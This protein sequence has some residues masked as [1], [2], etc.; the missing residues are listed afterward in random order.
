M[1]ISL[2]EFKEASSGQQ[3]QPTR[4]PVYNNPDQRTGLEGITSMFKE[5]EDI[6]EK[7]NNSNYTIET[8]KYLADRQK[9]LDA[10]GEQVT[11]GQLTDIQAKEEVSKYDTTQQNTYKTRLPPTYHTK[12]NELVQTETAKTGQVIDSLYKATVDS[13]FL[14]EANNTIEQ[15]KKQPKD[16]ALSR[17][18]TILVD[19]R[20]PLD[21]QTSMRNGFLKEYDTNALNGMVG[22]TENLSIMNDKGEVDLPTTLT[23]R[24]DKLRELQIQIR[25]N[26]TVTQNL[27]AEQKTAYDLKISDSIARNE[28]ELARYNASVTKQQEVTQKENEA[29]VVEYSKQVYSGVTP[30]EEL[31]AQIQ[32][33]DPNA[34]KEGMATIKIISDYKLAT[35][36]QRQITR[37]ELA[38]GI[39]AGSYKTIAERQK[40]IDLLAGLERADSEM[41]TREKEDPVGV[42]NERNPSAKLQDR[43]YQSRSLALAQEGSKIIPYTQNEIANM[44]GLWSTSNNRSAILNQFVDNTK[45]LTPDIANKALY[46]Q[47]ST[48]VSGD[49]NIRDYIVI[50]KL[51]SIPSAS[52]DTSG[53]VTGKS[54]ESLGA[55][56]AR[57]KESDFPIG[58]LYDHLTNT[59]EYR[60]LGITNNVQKRMV[61]ATYKALAE[62]SKINIDDTGTNGLNKEGFNENIL[63]QAISSLYGEEL[64]SD[65]FG[66]GSFN[67]EKPVRLPI[68]M[69][70][71]VGKQVL[72]KHVNNYSQ[73]SGMTPKAIRSYILTPYLDRAGTYVYMN[74]KNE[75]LV[76]GYTNKEGKGV[77]KTA[78][79]TNNIP[80]PFI[81]DFNS[82]NK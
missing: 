17:L 28:A 57:G 39:E 71:D 25:D 82:A 2:Q 65:W 29:L 53:N 21:K 58:K 40:A 8:T 1:A 22:A 3:L 49:D 19:P 35:A 67:A 13:K 54:Q 11:S 75:P 62:E 60:D 59:Q 66:S 56:L 34:V 18:E 36:E 51:Q 44:R 32:Q 42:Y 41:D 61:I 14:V 81:I 55:I 33:I 30:S 7:Q 31:T 78:T 16:V 5:Q 10:I 74:D 76:Y 12:L 73:Y 45:L 72:D 50:A 63:K 38:R 26:S 80:V 79:A 68:G 20:I 15:L 46:D 69:S 37:S 64:K 27:T 70:V 48:I 6:I 9:A 43:S 4:T 77:S 47:I 52:F 24:N 23:T